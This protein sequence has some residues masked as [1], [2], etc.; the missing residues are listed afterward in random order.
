MTGRWHPWA[1]LRRRAHIVLEWAWI[2]GAEALLE[3]LGGGRRRLTLDAGLDQCERRAALGHELVHDERGI[4]PSDDT[5][6]ALV[7]KE[8]YAVEA[9]TARR[10]V[11]L[12]ELGELVRARV[13]DGGCVEWRDVA[14]WFDVPRDVAEN[15]LRQLEQLARRRHPTTRQVA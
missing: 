11:P 15:A 10:L 13:C 7:R 8:E 9:E 4:F 14:E 3:D 2:D 6:M 5:P 12:G 1:E